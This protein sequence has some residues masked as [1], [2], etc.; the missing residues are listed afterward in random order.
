MYKIQGELCD[1]DANFKVVIKCL[2]S[3]KTVLQMNNGE[4]EEKEGPVQS[5]EELQ[6]LNTN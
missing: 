1:K 2:K 5:Q 6:N 3:W 4:W